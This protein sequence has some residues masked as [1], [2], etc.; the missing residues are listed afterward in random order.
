MRLSDRRASNEN[1]SYSFETEL[2]IVKDFNTQWGARN[3]Y[4]AEIL[5]PLQSHNLVSLYWIGRTRDAAA[6]GKA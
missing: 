2:Q 4:K 3:D 5:M 1:N 6:F